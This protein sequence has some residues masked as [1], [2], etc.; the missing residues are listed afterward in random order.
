MLQ[1]NNNQKS[2]FVEELQGRRDF[3]IQGHMVKAK[4]RIMTDSL[5]NAPLVY[6]TPLL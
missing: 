4:G 3:C 5:C 6:D 1:V 2:A